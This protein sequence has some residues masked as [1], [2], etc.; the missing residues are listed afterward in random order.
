MLLLSDEPAKGDE[1]ENKMIR[2]E[3]D[4]QLDAI[5]IKL[6]DEP[7]GYSRELDDNRIIDYTLNPGKTVG[8]DLQAVSEGV[9]LSGLPHAEEIKGILIEK[10]IKIL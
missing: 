9:K 10:G 2:V 5:Y 6:L 7:V 3:T 8:I 1:R 4:K